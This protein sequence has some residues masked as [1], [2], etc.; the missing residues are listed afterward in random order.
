MLMLFSVSGQAKIINNK[1]QKTLGGVLWTNH[2]ESP[3]FFPTAIVLHHRHRDYELFPPPNHPQPNSAWCWLKVSW[4][5]EMSS[6]LCKSWMDGNMSEAKEKFLLH[7]GVHTS[8]EHFSRTWMDVNW[9]THSGSNRLPNNVGPVPS[10]THTKLRQGSA[11]ILTVHGNPQLDSRKNR[12]GVSQQGNTAEPLP[13]C[14]GLHKH[15][16]GKPKKGWKSW[17]LHFSTCTENRMSTV[18]VPHTAGCKLHILAKKKK[19]NKR[20]SGFSFCYQSHARQTSRW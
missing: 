1:H 11:F 14:P 2:L 18:S 17:R 7:Q 6:P 20:L 19:N 8:T 12:L 15:C 10:S 13:F 16:P 4:P 3:H 9:F 5:L